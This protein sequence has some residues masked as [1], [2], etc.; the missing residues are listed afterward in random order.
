MRHQVPVVAGVIAEFNPSFGFGRQ[1]LALGGSE[2][3]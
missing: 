1:P 3:H 2:W